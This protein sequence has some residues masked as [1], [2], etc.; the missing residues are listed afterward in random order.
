MKVSYELDLLED[1]PN[2]L[3]V[4][5]LGL[6]AATAMQVM[7]LMIHP[8]ERPKTV[9]AELIAALLHPELAADI[10]IDREWIHGLITMM[11]GTEKSARMIAAVVFDRPLIRDIIVASSLDK[12][13]LAHLEI[14]M[15]DIVESRSMSITEC[16]SIHHLIPSVRTWARLS[17]YASSLTPIHPSVKDI[18][19]IVGYGL[20][21]SLTSSKRKRKRANNNA[22]SVSQRKRRKL[23]KSIREV[24]DRASIGRDACLSA[25]V[26]VLEAARDVEN[27]KIDA[28][29]NGVH[30]RLSL[31]CRRLALIYAWQKAVTDNQ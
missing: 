29:L 3:S 26:D 16:A 25:M 12:K 14:K 6:S 28:I 13:V 30:L 31:P 8:Y 4:S 19:E 21:C 17:S 20:A 24:S 9:S 5:P 22:A 2:V 23:R 27:A 18:R 15:Q 1:C 7:M 11:L 10:F